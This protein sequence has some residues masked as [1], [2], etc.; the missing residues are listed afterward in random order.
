MS[1]IGDPFDPD[2]PGTQ[3]DHDFGPDGDG[4]GQATPAPARRPCR[5]F[6]ARRGGPPQR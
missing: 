1:P 2:E 3:H 4:P 5:P 6:T